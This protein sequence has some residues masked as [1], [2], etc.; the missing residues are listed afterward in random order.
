[1]F[2]WARDGE[3][4]RVVE[5]ELPELAAVSASTTEHAMA[6]P[7]SSTRRRKVRGHLVPVREIV[8]LLPALRPDEVL[9][10]SIRCW[11]MAARLGLELAQR[12]A[13]APCMDQGEARWKVLLSRRDDRVRFEQIV[14]AAPTATR[15]SPTNR[16]GPVRLQSTKVVVRAFLDHLVDALYRSEAWPGTSRGWELEFAQ[17][18]AGDDPTFNPRDARYQGVPAMI[19]AWSSDNGT[20]GLR[21]G[22]TMTLPKHARDDFGLQ[23]FLHDS[24]DASIRI[25]LERGWSA[26]EVLRLGDR[27]YFHP[28]YAALQALARAKRIFPALAAALQG[29]TPR[30]V[31]WTASQAWP[32]LSV[33]APALRDAGFEVELPDAFA[34]EG[35]RRI[36]ARMRI[37]STGDY[38]MHLGEQ[39][40]YRWEVVLGDLVLTGADFAS[41]LA[42]NAPIVKFR[43]DWVLLDPEELA[44]LPEGLPKE[45]RLDA[46]AALRA[47]L[48]GQHDGVPVVADNRL[49]MMIDALRQPPDTPEPEG[50]DATLRPYQ[51]RGYAWLTCLGNLGLGACLADDMGLGKT[52]QVITHILRRHQ[53]G[54]KHLVVCPTSVL[55]NWRREIERFAPELAV[56]RHHGMHRN[57]QRTLERADVVL[58]TYGLLS[59]DVDALKDVGWDVLALDEAQA[60]K[61]P[62]SQRAKAAREIGARHRVAMSGTPVENRLEE[63]WSIMEFLVPGMLGTRGHFRR[64]VALPVEKFGDQDIAHRLKLGV[65]PFLLRRLKTDPTIIDDLPDKI[66]RI[67]YCSL[68]GEQASLYEQAAEEFL[69][70]IQESESIERRGHVLA[71]LTALKQICNHPDQYLKEHGELPGRSGKLDRASELL[72]AIVEAGDRAIVFTQYKEMGIRIAQHFGEVLGMEVPFLHGGVAS[73]HRDEM[74]RA[75]QEDEDVS[76]VLIISLRAG[77][78]G[79]NLTRATH[80]LH[81]D[82]W[83]NPAVEDQATDRAYRIGQ[84]QNVQVYKFVCQ[85]TLEERIDKMLEDKRALAESVVGSGERLVTELDD[86][87]LRALV[88][89]G[90]DAVLEDG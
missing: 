73:H 58:T 62:D 41:I 7:G 10:D 56:G 32:F 28:A 72:D 85:G 89:L 35:A 60:I 49:G 43:G 33:G 45:G 25:P 2:F 77:G 74:V 3:L 59:R 19:A 24:E 71:M 69:R 34:A 75:F 14:A 20:V 5:E 70:R 4:S 57:L 22:M 6:W 44:R 64:H 46:A 68:S 67:D 52:V 26:G 76:P 79:L 66:E 8:S 9:S 37:E 21:V 86:A 1:L 42:A 51:L 53:P 38:G 23:F 84:R 80:V 29:P 40:T 15:I 81:Y 16:R 54:R 61:N 17:A 18:L 36:R 88:M 83:W 30:S 27:E 47:V 55:G 65:S 87:A 90:E 12:Q 39:L 50:L 31:S 13:V 63:L 78:T 82:R 48:T 11:S